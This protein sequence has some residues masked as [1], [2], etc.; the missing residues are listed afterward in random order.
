MIELNE[1]A[2]AEAA[3]SEHAP[4]DAMARYLRAVAAERR[5]DARV[6]AAAAWAAWA[7]ELEAQRADIIAASGD[8][9]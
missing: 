7:E 8:T 5:R 9:P 2:L 6:S 1:D 4:R 3:A